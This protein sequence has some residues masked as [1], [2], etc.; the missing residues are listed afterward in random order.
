MRC[1]ENKNKHELKKTKSNDILYPH[2]DDPNFTLK[3][4]RKKGAYTIGGLDMF[5]FQGIASA[6]IW[7]NKNI[8]NSLKLNQIKKVLKLEL[9]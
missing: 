1:V 5:I 2:L 6:E 3:L 7:E 9:C 8:T 4:S